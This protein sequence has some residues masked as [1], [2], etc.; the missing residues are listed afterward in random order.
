MT[1][2]ANTRLQRQVFMKLIKSLLPEKMIRKYAWMYRIL[3]IGEINLGKGEWI[4]KVDHWEFV[5]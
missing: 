2:I 4:W 5:V 1:V 3:I